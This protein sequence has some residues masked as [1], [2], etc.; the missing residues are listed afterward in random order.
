MGTR[1]NLFLIGRRPNDEDQLTEM[2]AVLW[3]FEPEL[4]SLWLGSL[5]LDVN[6]V[7]SWDFDTQYPIPAGGRPDIAL[8]S[9]QRAFVLVESKL[10]AGLTEAQAVA[11]TD[12]LARRDEPLRSLVLVT[13]RFE[14]WPHAA[15]GVAASSGIRLLAARWQEMA[16]LLA[17]PGEE[18]LA[19]DFVEMLIE[20][21]LVTPKALT[22]ADW[23]TWNEGSEVLGRLEQL[24]SETTPRLE[25]L[26]SK[27][28][29]TGRL[30]VG[31]RHIYRQVDFETFQVILGFA[32][33]SSASRPN[34]PPVAFV[35]VLNPQVPVRE[36]KATAQKAVSLLADERSGINWGDWPTISRLASEVSS[37]GDFREQV[38]QLLEFV[39][40]AIG[41]FQAVGYLPAAL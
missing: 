25:S 1:K 28:T 37:A 30:A 4:P 3:Q 34:E 39:R 23:S 22:P 33:S 17:R 32:P 5:G 2:L 31:V 11:Y 19:A 9:E 18:S 36:R 20:E 35:A 27:R 7:G 41:R 24:I 12:F 6:E 13:K 26:G 38:E 15:E 21:G 29:R 14:P 8:W 40:T 16:E 10:D